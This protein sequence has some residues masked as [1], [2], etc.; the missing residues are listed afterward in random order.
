MKQITDITY[1]KTAIIALGFSSLV[2][3][4]A[5]PDLET[6]VARA[7][8]AGNTPSASASTTTDDTPDLAVTTKPVKGIVVPIEGS[9]QV[10]LPSGA[11]IGVQPP[12]GSARPP[13]MGP[14][15]G[16]G[17]IL[18][19]HGIDL[20]LY[21]ANGHFTNR[22]TG[23]SP[24][25][26][27]DY[28]ELSVSANADLRKLI[29]VPNTKVH[30]T[31]VW[32]PPSNNTAKFS[33][34][35]ATAFAPFP[36][37]QRNSSLV[38]LTLSH[39]FFD[40]KLHVEYGRMNLTDDFMV[41]TM[42]SGCFA[43]TPLIT[44]GVPPRDRSLLGARMSYAVSDHARLGFAAVE[45]N[46]ALQSRA[47]GWDWG[48][49]TR[50]G[51]ITIGNLTYTSDFSDSAYPLNAEVGVYHNNTP[52]NDA[53][54]NV[55]GSSQALTFPFGTPLTHEGGTWGMYAQ[56]RKLVWKA[57]GTDGPVPA[58]VALYGGAYV[59][60]GAG[61]AY[62]VEAFAGIEYG[63]FLKNN[64]VALVGSTWRYMRLSDPR[65]K[66]E[67]QLGDASGFGSKV[68]QNTFAADVHAQYGLAPGILINASAQYFLHPNRVGPFASA[69]T[70]R[71]GWLLGTFLIV[72]LGRI[73]GLR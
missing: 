50:K 37:T 48:S 2:A 61:Q 52:Y 21:V 4:A 24:G 11:N 71:S 18:E 63:G 40:D 55:D 47:D 15:S 29:G 13:R 27:V 66:F 10:A 36:P 28:F 35:V 32:Q 6:P 7:D 67:Q 26:S 46:F 43:A 22:S 65:A 56:A 31:E 3:M 58:N 38:K 20:G 51:W 72:D 59:T 45:D 1:G 23:V 70:S 64:P 49:S 16:I 53:L 8:A 62:P 39:D 34:Q 41:A 14:L 30:F 54:R 44:L 42:C 33:S 25:K 60:P 69:G 12:P 17:D 5:G 19:Q 68:Y 73:S 57:A 9:P